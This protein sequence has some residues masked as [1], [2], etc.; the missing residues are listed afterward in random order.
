MTSDGQFMRIGTAPS[1]E[2]PVRRKRSTTKQSYQKHKLGA[3]SPTQ[4]VFLTVPGSLPGSRGE[5]ETGREFE[6]HG[7]M[8]EASSYAF[9]PYPRCV[10][11]RTQ[12]KAC[13][14][15]LRWAVYEDWYR[16]E[17]RRPGTKEK[18]HHKAIISEAQAWSF[19]ANSRGFLNGSWLSSASPQTL[20]KMEAQAVV[21]VSGGGTAA[22]MARF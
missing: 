6:S 18:K 9:R 13:F 8:H 10:I 20:S 7:Y 4:G 15:D 2:G 5:G 11:A 22:R 21:M 3:S 12:G 19:F 14:H 16:P 17:W 1:G